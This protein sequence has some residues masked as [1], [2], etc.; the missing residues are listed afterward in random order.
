MNDSLFENNMVDSG[1][2]GSSFGG[3]SFGGGGF[4]NIMENTQLII[5]FTILSVLLA[6]AATVLSFIFITPEK[7]REK[8]PKFFQIVH[9]IFNF[10][11]LIIEKILKALYIFSTIFAI[12]Y[13]F[14]MIFTGTNFFM[15][16]LSMIFTPIVIRIGFEFAMMLILLVKNVISI[17]KKMKSENKDVKDDFEF[18][19][20]KLNIKPEAEATIV[21]PNCGKEI[22]ESSSFCANCGTQ[23]N[24]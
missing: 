9:D 19:Y 18:D 4:D 15:C 10:N 6:I 7:K 16:L 21:C 2:G 13:F 20:S 24:K 23:I 1:F 8:L 22:P 14:F 17:N 11:G 5:V 3:S 12:L